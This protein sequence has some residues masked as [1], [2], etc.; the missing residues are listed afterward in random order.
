M[1]YIDL[2]EF[3]KLAQEFVE[4]TSPLVSGRTINIMNLDGIIIAS[5]EK[6]RI[7]TYHHGARMAALTGVPVLITKE[8]KAQYP[9]A[10][11]GYNLPICENGKIIG[12]IGMYGAERET[13]DAANLLRVYVTQ[14]LQQHTKYREEAFENELRNQLL[15]LYLLGK[16]EHKDEISQLSSMISLHLEF[17]LVLFAVTFSKRDEAARQ[18]HKTA[19]EIGRIVSKASSVTSGDLYGIRD[20]SVMILHSA[21]KGWQ[22]KE[23][24]DT[25]PADE[26]DGLPDTLFTEL[27][28]FVKEHEGVRLCISHLCDSLDELNEAYREVL[29]LQRGKNRVAWAETPQNH[30]NYFLYRLESHGGKPFADRKMKQLRQKMDKGQ[31]KILFDTARCYYEQDGSVQKAAAILNIHKNTLQYR[32]KR[33]YES[34]HMEKYPSFER[35]FFIRMLLAFY[36]DDV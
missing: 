11:E 28:S 13:A 2:P 12:V 35:E 25:F 9:G 7:G 36:G 20:N 4:A 34:L 26:D 10:K 17:P 6:E 1:G 30:F 15:N 33:L 18:L 29:V 31:L 14:F 23:A 32:M 16:G 3:A 19:E 22:K 21:G 8:N 27:Q 5:T 24:E